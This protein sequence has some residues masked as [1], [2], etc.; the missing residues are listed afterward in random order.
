VSA[1]ELACARCGLVNEGA[2][3][4]AKCGACGTA[5]V[6]HAEDPYEGKTFGLDLNRL[7]VREA[8]QALA[9][10]M[11]KSGVLA[12]VSA[13][14]E[15][16]LG[17][18]LRKPRA[19]PILKG[20][21]LRYRKVNIA[22]DTT[23]SKNL[24]K[25]VTAGFRERGFIPVMDRAVESVTPPMF[26]R[27]FANKDKKLYAIATFGAGGKMDL[28]IIAPTPTGEKALAVTNRPFDWLDNP[29]KAT[30]RLPGASVAELMSAMDYRSP[31][32]KRQGLKFSLKDF[33]AVIAN[34]SESRFDHA[35]SGRLIVKVR[36]VEKSAAPS[37]GKSPTATQC[38][39]HADAMVVSLCA[40]CSKPLCL[41]C[42]HRVGG[43]S[44]CMSCMPKETQDSSLPFDISGELTPAG[45]FLR[46]AVKV[47]EIAGLVAV[48]AA[49]FPSGASAGSVVAF[50]F[51]AAVVSLSYFTI[52]MVAWGAT[53]LQRILGVA[54]VDVETGEIPTPLSALARSGYLFLAMFT[55][56]PAIGYLSA[57]R[58]M[59]RRGVHDRIAGTIVL[60]RAGAIKEKM[61]MVALILALAASGLALKG[62][63]GRIVSMFGRAFGGVAPLGRVE[64]AAKWRVN[65]VTSAAYNG[66]GVVAG[67]TGG[68]L[69]GFDIET[70][71]PV[72]KLDG[73]KAHS[74]HTD[75]V[76][77]S[78]VFTGIKDNAHV[79]GAVFWRDGAIEWKAQ[80]ERWPSAPPAFVPASV[81]SSDDSQITVFTR[82]GKKLWS[83]DAGGRI[84]SITPA[85]NAFI[86]ALK[87]KGSVVFDAKTGAILAETPGAPAAAGSATSHLFTR[88]G[89]ANLAFF[90]R[91]GGREWTLGRRLSFATE[92][93]TRPGEFYY[94]HQLAVRVSDGAIAFEYPAGCVCVG[95]VKKMAALSCP[96]QKKLLLADGATGR[97]QATFDAPAMDTVKLLGEEG[98]GRL[99]GTAKTQGGFTRVYVISIKTGLAELDVKET[100]EFR[101]TPLIANLADRGGLLLIAGD[102]RMG[103]YD[104]APARGVRK[105]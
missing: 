65:D 105:K 44:L 51:I 73:V 45:F 81:A 100:G 46:G 90:P 80:V 99:L 49:V 86:T 102:G 60:T 91:G 13:V 28:E 58:G 67:I 52:P 75:T 96:I 48:F 98:G 89:Q 59:D 94:A 76:T 101:N 41:A 16:A 1:A 5:L 85:G 17:R 88:R 38:A 71:A 4:G 70:G 3:P 22:E 6:G 79:I 26:E 34:W 72:W 78:Y 97:I 39:N 93:T 61:G 2:E 31:E 104:P 19:I 25:S 29:G 14:A 12:Q 62:G 8:A 95:M 82:T 43:K 21:L 69:N 66:S 64:M 37:P 54:V 40:A 56:I 20:R 92:E 9:R 103:L 47:A 15:I 35:E 42:G 10:Y 55:F 18:V 33:V 77:G 84:A 36:E 83:A 50:Q 57:L 23:V 63:E 53:P 87:G 32:N 68:A 24:V 74:V 11:G 30:H 27:L 7:P